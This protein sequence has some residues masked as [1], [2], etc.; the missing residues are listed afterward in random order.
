MYVRYDR[1]L[2]VFRNRVLRR[3][4]RSKIDEVTG[5]RRKLYNEGLYDLYPS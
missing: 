1:V 4:F 5:E 2:R 3:I